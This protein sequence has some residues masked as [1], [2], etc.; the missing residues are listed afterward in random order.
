MTKQQLYFEIW[1]R[2]F[3]TFLTDCFPHHFHKEFAYFHK[4][5]ISLIRKNPRVALGAPRGHGKSE[6]ISFGYVIWQLLCNKHRHLT[7]IVSNNYNNACKYLT[8]I[9]E[10]IENNKMIKYVFGNL[11]SE[12]WSENEAEFI[13]QVDPNF[14]K[15]IVVGGNEFKIRGLK[16]LQY[17]PDL[18][19]IDDAEDDELVRSDLRRENFESWLLKSL[20]P[21]MTH[22]KLDKIVMVGTILHRDSQLSKLMMAEGKYRE[23]V[24][25]KYQ[26]ITEGKALWEDHITLDWLENEQ[27]KDPY[28]FAQEYMNNPVPFEHAMFKESYFDNYSDNDLPKSL[29]INITC[30]LACT[31]KSYSDYTVILPVGVDAVGDLWVLPYHRAKYED[32]DKIIEAMFDMYD[33]YKDRDG[34][35]FGRFAVEKNAFQRFLIKN[36]NRERKKRGKRFPVVEIQAKGDKTQRIAQLQP[37]F[38]SGDIHI[39]SSMLDLK[40]ELLD[41]PRAQHDD[42]SDALAMQLEFHRARPAKKNVTDEKFKVTPDIQYKKMIKKFKEKVVPGVY[43]GFLQKC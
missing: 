4:E 39:K 21:A 23:W 13:S 38:S 29:V 14:R 18:V 2:D 36:F 37:L 30:D 9:K 41:F 11:K 24:S 5:M 7:L 6:I 43:T 28:K 31:D 3:F 34:W 33:K 17:R 15:K 27:E 1:K 26:A 42:I 10:E 8:P 12:K 16:F 35:T 40:S 22:S 25:K 20:T 19:I 32:P